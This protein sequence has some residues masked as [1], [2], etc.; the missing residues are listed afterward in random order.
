V[1]GQPGYQGKG[2]EAK[3]E[4]LDAKVKQMLI[5]PLEAHIAN[6][7]KLSKTLKQVCACT[8]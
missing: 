1:H 8:C 7:A 4:E 5:G 6:R 3:F 2:L